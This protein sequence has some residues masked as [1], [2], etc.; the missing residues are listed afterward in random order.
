MTSAATPKHTPYWWEDGAPLPDL[1]KTPP[2][3]TQ[4][5]IVGAGYTGLSAALTAAALGAKVTVIDAGIPGQGAS[6]RNG[7]MAG[8]H[9]RVSLAQMSQKFGEATAQAVFNEATPA[10]ETLRN[11]ISQYNIDCD[12]QQTGRIQLAWSRSQFAAQKALA[13]VMNNQT[14]FHI[15]VLEREQVD[16]HIQT[17]QYFGGLLFADHGA[18]QPRKL[19]DGLMRAALNAGVQVIQQCPVQTIEPLA[20][21][22]NI[23]RAATQQGTTNSGFSAKTAG[24][25]IQADK[26]IIATNGYTQGRG[27]FNWLSRRVFP[28]PSYLIATEPLTPELIDELAPGRRMMV[29]TRARYS[30]W[31]VSPD[32]SRI[33]FGGRASLRN[34]DLNVA[35]AR[36]KNT[37][38]SIWPQ[39][40]PYQISHVWTGNTG[41]TFNHC[42]NV[43]V[44]N[45]LH[46]ALGY[47]GGGV[48]LSPYLGMKVAYQALGDARGATAYSETRLQSKPYFFGGKPW[49]LTASSAWY[50]QVVDRRQTREAERDHRK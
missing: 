42:A 47:C 50:S 27:I 14:S 1:P 7:G 40:Q 20:K 21:S 39:L 49:F 18:V 41:F 44:E 12:Y 19:H 34:I 2:K 9:P 5:L 35:A 17:K 46:Y 23:D 29:E 13:E 15:D 10:F 45:G 37:M 24:G 28:V 33:I 26:V 11:L 8:A 38:L 25:D 30:Y 43:G 32:G 6:T 3:Q 4:L 22:G 48:V 31:R 36:L 16:E